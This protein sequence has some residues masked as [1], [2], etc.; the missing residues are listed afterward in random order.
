MAGN[1]MATPVSVIGF[2][3]L[4]EPRAFKKDEPVSDENPAKY[5]VTME[6]TGDTAKKVRQQLIDLGKS[7]VQLKIGKDGVLKVTFS[8]GEKSGAPRLVDAEGNE[9]NP[10]PK[11]L[12]RNTLGKV[13]F[14][15]FEY[16]A[17][18]GGVAFKL[19]AV[20][21]TEMGEGGGQSGLTPI[22]RETAELVDPS[23]ADIF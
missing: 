22:T 19:D 1:S 14:T 15:P 11:F 5:S 3:S 23:F 21:V 17:F 20:M 13:L 6:F 8:R 4:T 9:L 10:K 7:A 12:P 18:G 2:N 16:T